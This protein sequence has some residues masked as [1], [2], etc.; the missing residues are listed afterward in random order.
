VAFIYGQ[1]SSGY[2]TL[3]AQQDVPGPSYEAVVELTYCIQ[4]TPSVTLQPDLQYVL[5]P[6][7]TQE[8]GNA[9]VAGFR[10]TVSF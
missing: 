9:L 10:A 6:G 4:L 1:M 8:N 2:R 5:H 7:G 3:A